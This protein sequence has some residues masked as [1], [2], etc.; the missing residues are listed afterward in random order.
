MAFE[1]QHLMSKLQAR[2]PDWA[3]RWAVVATPDLHPMFVSQDGPVAEW[4][5]P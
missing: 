1:W 3:A 2:S 5:R 4:E